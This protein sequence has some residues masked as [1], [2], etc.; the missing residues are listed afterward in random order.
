MPTNY[1]DSRDEFNEP[2]SPSETPLSS[3]GTG[4]RNHV[5]HHRDLGD[6]VVALETYS[7]TVAHDHSGKPD[8]HGNV[9][10]KLKQINTHEDVDTDKSATSIHH[11]LGFGKT[12]AA[13]GNHT[14]NYGDLLNA[15]IVVTTSDKL[16]QAPRKG[17]IA[18]ETDTGIFRIRVVN[19][20]EPYW[21]LLPWGETPICKLYQDSGQVVRHAGSF[22]EWD[23][24]GINKFRMFRNDNRT[25]VVIPEKGHYDIQ[26]MVVFSLPLGW[27]YNIMSEIYIN[28]QRQDGTY[29]RRADNTP[30]IW[31]A[32]QSVETSGIFF[33]NKGDR[34]SIRARH[35]D[36]L[37]KNQH[38]FGRH[39]NFGSQLTVAYRHP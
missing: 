6:A 29:S 33:L 10:N 19:A 3:A 7:A 38:S 26:A 31:Q 17:L 1:P 30:R 23:R 8:I 12:Q 22:M 18:Y 13:P 36:D 32:P 15:P 27:S 28:G 21:S 35:D 16:P 39:E 9:T 4:T 14:H 25:E 34:V 20:T 11:T 2:S 24:V 37:V 5:E